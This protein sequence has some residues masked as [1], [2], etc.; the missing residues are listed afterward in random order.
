MSKKREQ[1]K[2]TV[3]KLRVKKET[4]RTLSA[5]QLE[6]VAGGMMRECCTLNYSGCV[7]PQH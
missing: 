3:R 6:Q 5:S 4:L 1:S 2:Q 7:D